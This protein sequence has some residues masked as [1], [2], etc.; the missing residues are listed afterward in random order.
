MQIEPTPKRPRSTLSSISVTHSEDKNITYLTFILPLKFSW[1]FQQERHQITLRHFIGYRISTELSAGSL[2]SLRGRHGDGTKLASTSSCLRIQCTFENHRAKREKKTKIYIMN[3]SDFIR[4]W[5]LRSNMFAWC[6]AYNQ[7]TMFFSS[8]QLWR[9]SSWW[10]GQ[11][12][13]ISPTLDAEADTMKRKAY[14]AILQTRTEIHQVS[15][16]NPTFC[17][18]KRFIWDHHTCWLKVG[19]RFTT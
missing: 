14:S 19:L 13:W 18:M 6:R 12:K 17:T 16:E 5:L 2:A 11:T 3:T 15:F 8:S 1:Q 4:W 10:V 9:Q 7:S